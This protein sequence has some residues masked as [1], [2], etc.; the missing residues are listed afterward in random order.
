MA[1]DN[2]EKLLERY[3]NGETSLKE[4]QQLRNYFSQNEVA[5]HLE[6]YRLMFGYFANTKKEAFTK[7]LPIHPKKRSFVYQWI[8]VAAVAVIMFGVFLQF[9]D[10]NSSAKTYADLTEEEK[11]VYDQTKEAFALLSSKFNQGASNVSV[12]GVVGSQFDKGAEKVEYV[13]EFSKKTNEILKKPNKTNKN[14]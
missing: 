14:K 5:P 4:E 3:D 9:N 11:E 1:L 8:A 10:S 7:E 12:L 6:S 2:I 13:S